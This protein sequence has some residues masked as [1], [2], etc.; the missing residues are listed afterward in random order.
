MH[1]LDQR[2]KVGTFDPKLADCEGAPGSGNPAFCP[3]LAPG[4]D[5]TCTHTPSCPTKSEGQGA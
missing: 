4:D 5:E 1:M 3:P 2:V